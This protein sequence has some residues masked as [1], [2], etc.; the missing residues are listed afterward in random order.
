MESGALRSMV[1]SDQ[2]I[3]IRHQHAVVEKALGRA[4]PEPTR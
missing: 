1:L 3:A 2:E 4:A